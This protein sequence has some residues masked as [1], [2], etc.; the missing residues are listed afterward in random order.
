MSVIAID[1]GGT[2]IAGAIFSENGKIIEQNSL[3]LSGKTGKDVGQLILK[4]IHSLSHPQKE[5]LKSIGICVPG[6]AGSRTGKVWA[7]N[8][9]GWE[10]YPLK[11]ELEDYFSG[12]SVRVSIESDRTCYIL[13]EVW[14]GA[15]V[16]CSNA[17]YISVGTGIGAGILMDGRILHG[18]NDIVGATGWM[19]LQSPFC[20][21][22]IECGCFEYYSSGRG[23]ALNA[24][25][26]V[27]SS[28]DYSGCLR[29]SEITTRDV[30]DAFRRND[31][32]AV[33]VIRKAVEMW[34]MA[35][36]NFV[37]LFN[38][39]K[40]I[41]GGGVFG[42]AIQFLDDI[43]TEAAKWAQPVSMKSVKIERSALEGYAGIY[44]A[45]YMALNLVKEPS[46]REM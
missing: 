21:D 28:P 12:T 14:K 20:D 19:A 6:I 36:A 4:M 18:S 26:I 3:P 22:Y 13:G 38:P 2:K 25:K 27:F 39:E 10:E 34:G 31:P 40:I 43:R 29:D 15:A 9:P 8:I 24:R 44:G 1:L 30:F 35:A 23:I 16:G 5:E 33:K 11:A 37:S 46:Q 7:P 42:P 45:A 17:I 41:F 32:V